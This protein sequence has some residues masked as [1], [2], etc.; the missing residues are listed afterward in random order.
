MGLP[1][2]QCWRDYAACKDMPPEVFF[3]D[4]NDP[5]ARKHAKAI[6]AECQVK[7][8]CLEFALANGGRGNVGAYGIWGGMSERE[9]ERLRK[10]R[11]REAPNVQT[12]SISA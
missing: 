2:E 8:H 10:R 11:L 12:Q 3:P 4:R 1:I 7:E 6:C 5:D 9:R